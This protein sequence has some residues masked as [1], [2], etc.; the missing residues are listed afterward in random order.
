MIADALVMALVGLTAG[1]LI[2]SVGIGG[3]IVVPILST[4]LAMDVRLAVATSLLAFCLASPVVI[5]LY[6]R[7]GS[8]S[9]RAAMWVCLG[10]LPG[11]VPGALAVAMVDARLLKTV[12]AALMVVT[13][14]R[15]FYRFVP[16]NRPLL[17]L[18]RPLLFGMGAV[19]GFLSALTG[20]G[21]PVTLI[22]LL[23]LLK[24][25]LLPSIGL[26][27]F[28]QLPVTGVA[29]A[30]NG[31][32]GTIVFLPAIILAAAMALGMA[33]GTRLAHK[34]SGELLLRYVSILLILA[35]AAM[36][37]TTWIML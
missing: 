3:V 18:G 21:G 28:V 9:W 8:I 27:Q 13:G 22:P 25:A 16:G 24:G 30:V 29:S 1:V 19:T 34:M 32:L 23:L 33:G 20:T 26:A 5:V 10:V 36:V 4:A 14:L 35:G 37:T 7:A 11:T 12:I 15:A 17:E 2:G 6:A 31:A